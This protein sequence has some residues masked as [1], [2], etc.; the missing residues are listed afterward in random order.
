MS[1]SEIHDLGIGGRSLYDSLMLPSDDVATKSLIVEAARAKDRLDRL[2]RITSG[3]EEVWCRIFTGEGEMI[4]KLDTAVSEHRQ[5]TT[6]FR[7][8]L[9]EIQRRQGDRGGVNE[10]D[11]LVGL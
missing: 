4:L 8:V 1:D 9:S 5:L 3:E 2:N 11:G 10:E 7:Q 6:A